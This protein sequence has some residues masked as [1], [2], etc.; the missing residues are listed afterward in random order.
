M[1]RQA[2][3]ID[4]DFKGYLAACASTELHM[5]WMRRVI[6]WYYVFL[7]R[8]DLAI[9]TVHSAGP[10]MP[11]NWAELWDEYAVRMLEA[12]RLPGGGLIPPKNVG[13]A[14]QTP[15]TREMVGS[16]R[17]PPPRRPVAPP[18]LPATAPPT[19][20]ALNPAG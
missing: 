19:P 3:E 10:Q 1:I 5:L 14:D 4:P 6:R 7:V 13:A 11:P 20:R 17:A 15:I 18:C 2:L 8:R 9:Y 16:E 12:R